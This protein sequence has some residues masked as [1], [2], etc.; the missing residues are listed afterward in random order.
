MSV[1]KNQDYVDHLASIGNA[2]INFPETK[3][4]SLPKESTLFLEKIYDRIVYNNQQLLT[5]PERPSFYFIK[6]N[7]PFLFS[8]PKGQFYFSTALLSKYLKS[9]ELF[10]AA[11]AAEILR[12]QRAIYEK[13]VIIPLGFYNAEKMIELTRLRPNTKQQVNEWTYLVLK[14]SGYDASA[15]LNWIQIQ[16]RNTLDFALY[17]G[18]LLGISREEHMFK[19]FMIKQGSVDG[20]RRFS[21]SN[22]SQEFYKLI[23]IIAR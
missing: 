8:L 17:L 6:H 12:S 23:N 16:N 11:F 4:V 14:R 7:S 2:Y 5:R 19:N 22:S 21:E 20:E 9:E 1:L 15:Y 18:D 13:N 10:V 3:M